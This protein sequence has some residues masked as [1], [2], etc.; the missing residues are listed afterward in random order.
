VFP[1]YT[2]EDPPTG[3]ETAGYDP[4][5][6]RVVTADGQLFRVADLAQG[7]REPTTW[8]QLLRLPLREAVP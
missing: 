6:G 2:V 3:L 5:T 1:R 4:G 8:Q 7:A